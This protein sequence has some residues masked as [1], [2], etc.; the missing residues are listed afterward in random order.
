[1][2][3]LNKSLHLM[4]V[5]C[6][7]CVFRENKEPTALVWTVWEEEIREQ[8]NKQASHWHNNDALETLEGDQLS[9]TFDMYF[10]IVFCSPCNWEFVSG[11]MVIVLNKCKWMS[12]SSFSL[13]RNCADC[14]VLHTAFQQE[15]K[16]Q[17]PLILIDVAL[18]NIS[19]ERVS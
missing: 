11:F 15:K 4:A 16:C 18:S 14:A 7:E 19:F 9:M 10:I 17:V 2:Y 1:M 3:V 6:T 8:W 12:K 13:K 5:R